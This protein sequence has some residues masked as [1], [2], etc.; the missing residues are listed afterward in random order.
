MSILE[1]VSNDL[2][3]AMKARDRDRATTLR[4]IRAAF[5]EEMK[6]DGADT[7][8]D[9]QALA[10]L[11]R[12]ARQRGE[13]IEAFEKGGRPDLAEAEKTELALIETFLPQLADEATTRAWVQAAIAET[14][15][16]GPGGIGKVMGYLMKN[17][18]NDIDGKLAKSIA[19]ELL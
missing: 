13:S 3:A 12:L 19:E 17:H 10:I 6:K 15:A 9:D 18:K 16:A 11:R 14:G 5:I 4:G 7:V 1:R 2:N 8:P